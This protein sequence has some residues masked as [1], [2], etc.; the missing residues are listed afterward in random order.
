[1]MHD[2]PEPEPEPGDDE[3][4]PKPEME[5]VTPSGTIAHPNPKNI[6]PGGAA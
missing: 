2:P 4:E 6:V 3:G 5:L 1:M